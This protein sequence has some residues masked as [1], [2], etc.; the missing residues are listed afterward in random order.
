MPIDS[1]ALFYLAITSFVVTGFAASGARVLREFSRSQLEEYCRKRARAEFFDVVVKKHD[2]FAFAAEGLAIIAAVLFLASGGLWLVIGIVDP[3][4]LGW[5]H[6]SLTAAIT[7]LIML[8]TFHWIP[9]GLSRFLSA[10]IVYHAWRVWATVAIVM[11]PLTMGA[12][13][14]SWLSAR[15]AGRVDETT[16]EEDAFEDEILSM[17]DAGVRDGLLED[18]TLGMIEGVMELGDEDVSGIMHPR[19]KID[20]IEISQSLEDVL[21]FVVSSGRT[22]LPVYEETLDNVQG[23]LYVKDLLAVL[24]PD[25]PLPRPS[26]RELL[27]PAWEVPPT[28][29]LDT[30]LK[31]FRQSR[32]HMA[33]V[34]NEYGSVAGVVTIE[35]V[36]EEIVGEIIDES[37]KDELP[38]ILLI[39]GHHARVLGEARLDDINEQLGLSIPDPDDYE[40]IGGFVISQ[41][42]RLP[43]KG[44]ALD[45]NDIHIEVTEASKRRVAVVEIRWTDNATA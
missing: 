19:N 11:T 27:R 30:M 28:K 2:D 24:A 16:D 34:R 33:I 42:A 35:D 9:L 14:A 3:A 21:P 13:L 43:K 8:A 23:I 29:F 37:D 7:S 12:R 4:Q 41:L 10:P 36:L 39:S 45:F 26:L 31:E 15:L 25:A 6:F 22:R 17:A 32:T 40:S 5:F 38:Q 20:A 18:E 1:A 44:D